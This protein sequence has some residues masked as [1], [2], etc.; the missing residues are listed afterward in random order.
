MTTGYFHLGLDE[1]IEI[2]KHHD[3]G[4]SLRT[5]ALR[6][7]RSP[8]TISREIR[9]GQWRPFHENASYT[10]YWD[11]ALHGGERT[12]VQYRAA[13]A[14]RKATNRAARS[15]QP[16]RLC[17]DAAITY[18]TSKL[19]DGW[20]PEMIAGRA[21][22]DF[23]DT[24]S[25]QACAETIYRFI[26][27]SQ[28]RHRRLHEYLPHAGTSAANATAAGSTPRRSPTG[29]RSITAP[30]KSTPA[31]CSAIGKATASWAPKAAVMASTPRSNAIP[32]DDG[33]QGRNTELPGRHSRPETTLRS[34][35]RACSGFDHHG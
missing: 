3:R 12:K 6:L 10:D 16:T 8:S 23:P 35:A 22:L 34:P 18:L 1:R 7:G 17:S 26:Y 24:G 14:H 29:S 21:R 32:D 19:R 4:Q 5:I 33:H 30:K 25:M 20:T 9:R 28:N 13:R 31:P 15:H 2:E 11:P 27:A